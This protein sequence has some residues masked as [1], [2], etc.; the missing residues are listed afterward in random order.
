M[1]K[2]EA[3][4][5]LGVFRMVTEN[6]GIYDGTHGVSDGEREHS[7]RVIMGLTLRVKGGTTGHFPTLLSTSTKNIKNNATFFTPALRGNK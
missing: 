5:L 3:G 2:V 1:L 4:F 6:G 7:L